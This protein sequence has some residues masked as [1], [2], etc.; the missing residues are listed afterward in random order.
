MGDVDGLGVGAADGEDDGMSV[1][2]TD[3]TV[4]GRA[5]GVGVGPEL[6]RGEAVGWELILGEADGLLEGA[7]DG[8]ALG[9]DEGVV[10]G[11][12]VGVSEGEGD[13]IG[14]MDGA[15][16]GGTVGEQVLLYGPALPLPFFFLQDPEPKLMW[17]F[18][19]SA[20]PSLAGASNTCVFCK[21]RTDKRSRRSAFA[22][23]S[24]RTNSPASSKE[25]TLIL[26]VFF[27]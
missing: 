11:T 8:V 19:K 16:V 26:Q 25:V 2:D 22:S 5:D 6:G 3:G 27:K 24:S 7:A 9:F 21:P 23:T 15:P 17:F 4:V 13:G 10:V 1:G 12:F 18:N 14:V 20:T